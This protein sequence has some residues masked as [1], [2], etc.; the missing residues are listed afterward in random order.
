MCSFFTLCGT[1]RNFANWSHRLWETEIGDFLISP[2]PSSG[3]DS[4][5]RMIHGHNFASTSVYRHS[6][7]SH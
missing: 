2:Y 4:E 7:D 1:L 5:R 6:P 3:S